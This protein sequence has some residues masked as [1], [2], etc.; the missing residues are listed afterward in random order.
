MSSLP[1]GGGSWALGGGEGG[2]FPVNARE[3]YIVL[4]FNSANLL[5][6][7]CSRFMWCC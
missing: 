1:W 4:Y 2:G 7:F 5:S 3:S 6:G